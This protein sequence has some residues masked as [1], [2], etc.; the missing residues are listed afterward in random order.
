M[1]SNASI[2]EGKGQNMHPGSPPGPIGHGGGPSH[3][4][5]HASP[6]SATARVRLLPVVEALTSRTPRSAS[7]GLGSRHSSTC[8]KP[9]KGE[10]SAL[11]HE[12]ISPSSDSAIAW[13]RPADALLIRTPCSALMRFGE[14]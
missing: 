8:G 2:G 9:Q 12:Y 7:T 13:Y 14:D 10:L 1:P 11:P 5:P 6:V 3:P 4:Q